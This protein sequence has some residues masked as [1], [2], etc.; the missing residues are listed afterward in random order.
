MGGLN[1]PCAP[2]TCIMYN[3]Q[4]H[5]YSIIILVP[6]ATPR[7]LSVAAVT[8]RSLNIS[9]L[10][11]PEEEQ[12]GIIT[13]YSIVVEEEDATV[14]IEIFTDELQLVIE[15]LLPFHIYGVHVAAS[16][17]IGY[18]PS[19]APHLIETPEDGMTVVY[20]HIEGRTLSQVLYVPQALMLK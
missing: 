20:L 9:W 15:N 7:N 2:P 17:S 12:N 13:N 11:P 10:P 5:M 3:I 16:T 6:T 19:T 4:F 1:F 8:P 14:V 18:G